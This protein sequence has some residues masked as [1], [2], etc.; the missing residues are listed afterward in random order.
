MND[1]AESVHVVFSPSAAGTLRKA[2]KRL[3]KTDRV[4]GLPDSLSVGPIDPPDEILRQSW[5]RSVLRT[6]SIL[7]NRFDGDP[8]E[9]ERTWAEA[10]AP[11]ARPVF[12]TCLSSP[13]EHSCFLAFAARMEGRSFDVIDTTD[14][15]STTIDG[16]E[17]PGSTGVMRAHDLVASGLFDK[18]RAFSLA[19]HRAAVAAWT[20]LRRENAPFRIVRD[21]RLVSAPLTHY[22]ALL[23]EQAR[24]EWEIA[25]RLIGRVMDVLHKG[26]APTGHGRGDIA[27]DVVLLGRMIALGDNGALRIAG[28]GP[29]MRAFQVSRP[30]P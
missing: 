13:M 15:D 29:G 30:A 1:S 22:D 28:P 20:D 18:R 27:G 5:G 25:P 9:V 12:W 10:T 19:E 17:R 3:G 16:I 21:G 6:D 23:V 4:I 11:E 7:P 24:E 14:L 2:L 8:L 26:I